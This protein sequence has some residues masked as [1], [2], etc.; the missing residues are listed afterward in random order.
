MLLKI[1]KKKIS[2]KINNNRKSSSN[3]N[4]LHKI[5]KKNNDF[6]NN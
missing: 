3:N 5:N 6:K 4:N 1:K 2:L